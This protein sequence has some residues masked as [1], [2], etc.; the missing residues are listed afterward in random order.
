MIELLKDFYGIDVNDYREYNEGIIFFVN[1][2]YY[3]LTKCYY[4]TIYV[5][6]LFEICNK[7]KASKVRLHDFVFNKSGE[8]ISKEYILFKINVLIYDIDMSDII[9]F[10]KI[11]AD[12]YKDEYVFMDKFWEDKIDYLEIQLTE[13][14]NNKLINN[15]FDYYVG[16]AELLIKYLKRNY[17]K[18]NINLC[19]SHKSLSSLSSVEFYSP[20]NIGFDIYLKDI[21]AYIRFTGNK[22]LLYDLLDK[23]NYNDYQY[24]FV[25]MTFPFE[26]FYEVSNILVDGKKDKDL[27]KIVNN[28]NCYEKYIGEMQNV[29]GIYVF[30]WIKKE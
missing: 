29:F 7:L 10:N 19:L 11:N 4:D 2:N 3:L 22:E 25:R 23:Q 24:F 26:Y 12:E 14:S 16:I 30:S 15:S 21:A 6:K 18:K 27:I 5:N 20:L 1:G 28:V 13:L 8:L 9:G 17:D